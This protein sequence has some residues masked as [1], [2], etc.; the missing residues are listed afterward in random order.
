MVINIAIK[1]IMYYTKL[2]RVNC[3]PTFFVFEYYLNL[4]IVARSFKFYLLKISVVL[5]MALSCNCWQF[6][7]SKWKPNSL[8]ALNVEF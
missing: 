5:Q 6:S 2:Y 4:T 8:W 3:I 7:G 1:A